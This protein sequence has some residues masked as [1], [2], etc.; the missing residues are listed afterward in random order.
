MTK[1]H[2]SRLS[3]NNQIAELIFV[4]DCPIRL[5]LSVIEQ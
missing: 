1:R 3:L 2:W 5:S 4:T